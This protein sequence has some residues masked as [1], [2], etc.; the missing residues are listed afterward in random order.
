MYGI[1]SC[2]VIEGRVQVTS[3]E[4]ICLVEF[5]VGMRDLRVKS[6]T[7]TKSHPTTITTT[8][9]IILNHSHP[10][11]RLGHAPSNRPQTQATNAI[12]SL[13]PIPLHQ[14]TLHHGQI[15]DY[16]HD[17]PPTQTPPHP[18]YDNSPAQ[19]LDNPLLPRHRHP[20]F[21]SH[22]ILASPQSHSATLAHAS[23]PKY[24]RL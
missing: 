1:L 2:R 18:R 24:A 9:T 11:S 14:K 17:H 22:S 10:S 4:S 7:I 16:H 15:H 19:N 12:S 3:N 20:R 23:H 8:T 5:R 13:H 6:G 21:P